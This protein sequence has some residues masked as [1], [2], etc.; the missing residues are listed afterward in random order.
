VDKKTEK[1]RAS[2]TGPHNL[3]CCQYSMHFKEIEQVTCTY[4]RS[5]SNL[6]GCFI[7]FC[8]IIFDMGLCFRSVTN[9]E[10]FFP[11]VI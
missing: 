1:H 11:G 4:Q 2:K 5:L 7:C 8:C 9:L 10:L 3:L 6:V